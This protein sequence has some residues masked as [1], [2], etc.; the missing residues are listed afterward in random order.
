V[1]E[2]ER[3]RERVYLALKEI[4]GLDVLPG[5]GVVP[6]SNASVFSLLY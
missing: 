5:E 4:S 6:A 1:R 3:E 2:R